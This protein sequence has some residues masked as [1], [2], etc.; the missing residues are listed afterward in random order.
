MICVLFVG[1]FDTR[2]AAIRERGL[3]PN[4]DETY[5]NGV[6]KTTFRDADGNEISGIRSPLVEA[7][8]G[9]YVGWNVTASGFQ[10]GRY[11][12][13]TG[14]YIPF[15]ATRAERLAK[16]DPRLSLEERY[17]SHD[18]YVA[19]VKEAADVKEDWDY[20]EIIATIPAADA[21]PAV[22]EAC[23]L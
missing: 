18:A 17:P 8:L 14:G 12:G 22:S 3:E 9:S 6:R 1:D 13:N 19:K 4:K 5:D 23:S 21:Y 2:V 16:G 15:A 20:E 11:C 10:A 7:P